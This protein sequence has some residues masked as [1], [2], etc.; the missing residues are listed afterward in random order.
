MAANCNRR[1]MRIAAQSLLQ[2]PCSSSALV[3]KLNRMQQNGWEFNKTIA[4]L[5]T[6]F[7]N[8]GQPRPLL[9]FIF[10]LFKQTHY[11]F[12]TNICEK[13][14]IQYTVLGFE[15]TTFGT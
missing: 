15:P 11:N 10:G 9:W 3:G 8:V 2:P 4:F 14:S 12:T 1:K 13:M 7:L 5:K 6:F